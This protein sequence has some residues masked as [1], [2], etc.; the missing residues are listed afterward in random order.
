MRSMLSWLTNTEQLT[1]AMMPFSNC[2]SAAAQSSV[3]SALRRAMP[4]TFTGSA[5]GRP[6]EAP[7]MKRD[8]ETG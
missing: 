5:K 8:I 7:A 4:D 6:S 3:P 2:S 1:S